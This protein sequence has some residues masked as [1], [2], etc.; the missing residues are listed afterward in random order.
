MRCIFRTLTLRYQ[1]DNDCV[2]HMTQK[3]SYTT[4]SLSYPILC[5]RYHGV[6][7]TKCFHCNWN[8]LK[9]PL[10]W[11]DVQS[12]NCPR[13]RFHR[14]WIVNKT[15]LMKR[16]PTSLEMKA[17]ADVIV[18]INWYHSVMTIIV[19][20]FNWYAYMCAACDRL[21]WIHIFSIC[22]MPFVYEFIHELNWNGFKW[23][24]S[25]GTNNRVFYIIWI[26]LNCM[27]PYVPVAYII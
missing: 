11:S 3:K 17:R 8:S 13:R 9:I 25:I 14:I 23:K 22:R 4:L 15:S 26:Y 7:C 18:I 27:D 21:I 10:L 1:L 5:Y 20:A 2:Q 12:F 6:H 19:D 24:E 16:A